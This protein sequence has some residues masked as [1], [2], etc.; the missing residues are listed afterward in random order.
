M[1]NT[2][3]LYPDDPRQV[4]DFR[5]TGRV[6]EGGQGIVYRGEA[7]DGAA[8]AVKLLRGDLWG[9]DAARSRFLWEADLAMQVAR[10]CT[11]GVLSAGMAGERLYIVSEYID[12]PSLQRRVDSE[13]VLADGSLERL[14]IG[15]VT[16]LTAIHEAG[17][18][19]RDFKPANVILGS[20]GPRVIDFGIARALDTTRT[21]TQGVIG[22]PSYMAPERF[23]GACSGPAADVFAWAATMVY[24]ATGRPPF[25]DDVIPAVLNRILNEP[26][27]LTGLR[28]P[29]RGLVESC[30]VKDPARRPSARQ[31]LLRLLGGAGSPV[32]AVN[33]PA[34][35]TGR[36]AVLPVPDAAPGR[37]SASPAPTSLDTPLLSAA[38]ELAAA[39]T[40]AGSAETI[41][42]IAGVTANDAAESSPRSTG[43]ADGPRRSRLR[44]V[45]I[46]VAVAVA[47][48]GAV[49]AANAAEPGGSTRARATANARAASTPG[50]PAVPANAAPVRVPEI[51]GLSESAAAARLRGAGLTMGRVTVDCA[52]SR[53]KTVL[54][55]APAVGTTAAAHTAVDVVVGGTPVTVL[56][57]KGWPVAQARKVLERNGLHVTLERRR[58][59]YW[60]GKVVAQHPAAGTR[61]CPGS[62]V[63]LF[64]GV[65]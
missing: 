23:S 59:D 11:A 41:G 4:G 27:D 20:D 64:V 49:L 51:A 52:A 24:A 19:H 7:S 8:V 54:R 38:A 37:V 57:G 61:A 6:G 13:G 14:A 28:E 35:D 48:S 36:G 26:P 12:G 29:V 65:G 16:A 32:A 10:F 18:V 22:T 44:K 55:A 56:D 60:I 58:S 63:T 53:Q 5:L 17:I 42:N 3:P 50:S 47:A 30:L 39:D 45:F 31:V 46:P 43:R 15:T 1:P 40:I 21:A 2:T 25:G 9:D 34:A 62:D 33:A